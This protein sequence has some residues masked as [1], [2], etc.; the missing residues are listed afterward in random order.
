MCTDSNSR[1]IK[2]MVTT[3]S[4]KKINLKKKIQTFKLTVQQNS[5]LSGLAPAPPKENRTLMRKAG[6]GADTKTL[7]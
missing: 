5:N 2:L 1:K 7:R 3:S 6:F 4:E